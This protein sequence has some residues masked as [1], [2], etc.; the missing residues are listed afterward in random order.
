VATR[1]GRSAQRTTLLGSDVSQLPPNR[2]PGR[3]V[4]LAATHHLF[5]DEAAQRAEFF[6]L[7]QRL[8]GK[9]QAVKQADAAVVAYTKEV[10]AAEARLGLLDRPAAAH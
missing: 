1:G 6:R 10:S 3:L 2:S 9:E 8:K 4:D 7:S 5:D